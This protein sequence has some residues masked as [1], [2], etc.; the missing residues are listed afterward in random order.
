VL[1]FGR[2]EFSD[3][4]KYLFLSAQVRPYGH[5]HVW[6]S[7]NKGLLLELRGLGLETFDLG[8]EPNRT[9][10]VL[11]RARIAVFTVNPS[12]S[13][14]SRIFLAALAG[15]KKVQLWHGIGI[16]RLEMQNVEHKS[17]FDLPT[18]ARMRWSTE[19]D[20]IVSPS[21][22]FDRHWQETFG[23]RDVIR[24]GYPRNEA[25]LREPGKPELLNAPADLI[26]ESS[27]KKILIVPTW[28]TAAEMHWSRSMECILQVARQNNVEMYLK[29]HPNEAASIN[30]DL[31]GVRGRFTV[32]PANMDI[33]P[34]LNRFSCMVTDHSSMAFDSFLINMDLIFIE[35]NN[36]RFYMMELLE[37]SVGPTIGS[38]DD[39]VNLPSLLER[40]AAC[41]ENRTHAARKFF[42]TPPLEA[43]RTIHE[44]IEHLSQ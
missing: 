3:N 13:V 9:V 17:F 12:E 4:S 30:K 37:P 23:V 32:L 27:K 24:A 19:I 40:S 14:K 42:E 5:R 11:L 20:F 16:K 8:E 31:T 39:L 36:R 35:P 26:S 22:F 18:V 15:A 41:S 6:C 25:L 44:F 34:H 1:Y 21:G 2:E 33:Y 10:Q 28:G 7:Y 43:S 29:P 38:L